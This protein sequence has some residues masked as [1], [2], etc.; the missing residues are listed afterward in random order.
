MGFPATDTIGFGTFAVRG[1]R[2]SPRPP[3]INTAYTNTLLIGDNST[4]TLII[5]SDSHYGLI[6]FGCVAQPHCRRDLGS[7]ENAH[8]YRQLARRFLHPVGG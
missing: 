2:R 6:V 4:L 8:R 1:L 7:R 3:A 5:C